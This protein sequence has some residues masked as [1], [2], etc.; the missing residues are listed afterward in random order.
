MKELKEL[1]ET[2]KTNLIS[3]DEF[4][5]IFNPS[6]VLS[7]FYALPK[8]HKECRPVP[9]RPM[10]SGCNNLTQGASMYVDMILQPFV[11]TL[12]SYLRDTKDVVTKLK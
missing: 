6:P 7:T 11:V 3:D 4:R 10:V 8:V 9:G 2:A 1:L 12:P 5:F